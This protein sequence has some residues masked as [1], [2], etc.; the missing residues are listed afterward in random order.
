MTN[1]WFT[2]DCH[3]FHANILKYE[4]GY[5]PFSTLEEMHE[6]I[7]ERWNSLVKPQDRIYI[8][9]DFCFGADNL[10]LIC[11]RLNGRKAL[12][13]GNHDIYKPSEYAQY[14]DKVYGALFYKK[15]LLTHIPC[16]PK[17]MR[18]LANIH[19]HLHSKVVK[20]KPGGAV[21]VNVSL[22]QNNL[23]PLSLEEI[24]VKVY[25]QTED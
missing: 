25:K 13:M 8:L 22:E 9:G 2:S 6:T 7:I 11:P 20:H 3:F 21:Y 14:F 12:I 19:G 23:T 4:D 5:R 17:H 15:Y 16:H 24:N 10:N 18:A 1:T